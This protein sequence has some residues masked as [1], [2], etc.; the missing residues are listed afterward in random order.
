MP[1]ITSLRVPKKTPCH[2]ITPKARIDPALVYLVNAL[3]IEE[4]LRRAWL[5]SRPATDPDKDDPPAPPRLV[6]KS[7]LMYFVE[8]S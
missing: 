8:D 2:K 6:L 3:R 4:T 7:S 1:P 5:P